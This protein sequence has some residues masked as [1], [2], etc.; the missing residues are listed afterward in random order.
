MIASGQGRS[1]GTDFDDRSTNEL[2]SCG[3]VRLVARAEVIKNPDRDTLRHKAP[4]KV[5][6]DETRTTC[7]Q[8]GFA[9]ND[10]DA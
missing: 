1:Y 5:A 2:N 8:R 4:D 6:A 7:Y 3:D 10:R 9:R